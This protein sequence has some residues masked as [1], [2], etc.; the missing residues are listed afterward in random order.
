MRLLGPL[1]AVNFLETATDH[2]DWNAVLSGAGVLC[3]KPTSTE[4]HQPLALFSS[5]GLRTV[6]ADL[7]VLVET[8]AAA[9]PFLSEFLP[10][11]KIAAS[12]RASQILV[13]L[14]V[15]LCEQPGLVDAGGHLLAVGRKSK[16]GADAVT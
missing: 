13:D 14:E 5:A 9:N 10:V 15:A 2:L 3:T 8:C 6:L 7:G 12:E 4:F 11:P 1:D 16:V